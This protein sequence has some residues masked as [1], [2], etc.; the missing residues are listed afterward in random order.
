MKG[1]MMADYVVR[2]YSR[3]VIRLCTKPCDD[4]ES[5]RSLFL[6]LPHA[7][8]A[9]FDSLRD[10]ADDIRVPDGLTIQLK[11][12]ASDINSAI[13]LSIG[14]AGHALSLLSCVAMA[15]ADAP[16]P[17]WAYDASDGVE[18]REFR[19]CF[20]DGTGPRPTRALNGQHLVHL[21]EKNFNSFLG[22]GDV[23]D[24]FKE[25]VQ[26]SL[27][28]LRRGLSDNDDV[29][30]EFLTA[31]STMEGLDCVYCKLLPGAAVR[32]FKDG[33]KDVLSRLGR[34]E[35]FIPLERLRNDIAHGSM[36]LAQAT[37]TATD[38][39]ELTRRALV[40]M[41]LSILGADE[42]MI[43]EI[44]G[45]A[46]YKCKTRP[47]V[48]LVANIRFEPVEVQDLGGQ[49]QLMVWL[50]GGTY[51]KKEQTLE[52]HPDIRIQP[53]NLRNM[54]ARGMEVWGMSGPRSA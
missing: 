32:G 40:M 31:W 16:I 21:L 12:G 30:D 19:Y 37:Q 2:L 14:V 6:G 5:R 48:R 43:R 26:R 36:S 54:S 8:I 41:I 51:T 42:A 46:S 53:Q 47:H 49:P 13:S 35:A 24:D 45:Q 29:L 28:A 7:Q 4:E 27:I 34:P 33:M 52:Y 9:V 44:V 20:Y 22:R 11:L 50:E 3:S 38:H 15:S 10:V 23:K 1:W 39:V 25:R 17:I 18:D